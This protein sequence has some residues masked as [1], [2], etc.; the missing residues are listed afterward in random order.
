MAIIRYIQQPEDSEL[1][2]RF[3]ERDKKRALKA[4]AAYTQKI[5]NS[6]KLEINCAENIIGKKKK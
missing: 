3:K 1:L 6:L 2:K 4:I 5:K